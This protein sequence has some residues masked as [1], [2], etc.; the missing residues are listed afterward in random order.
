[1]TKCPDKLLLTRD[2]VGRALE[3]TGRTLTRYAQ[4]DDD[5]L[6][7][8]RPGGPQQAAGYDPADVVRW[9]IRQEL[10]KLQQA[11]GNDDA[12]DYHHERAR[13]TKAQADYQ[14][15]RNREARGELARVELIAFALANFGSQCAAILETLP[16]KIK[17]LV[18]SLSSE[19]VNEVRAEIVKAQNAAARIEID[20]TDAPELE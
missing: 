3:V 14:E 12:I 16:G 20:W 13:L 10:A 8:V 19:D 1:M 7:P 2:Q 9:A 15:I 17:R 18:P 4:R 6:T 5:P 11:A